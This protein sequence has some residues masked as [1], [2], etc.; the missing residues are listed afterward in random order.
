MGTE[1]RDG[2]ILEVESRFGAGRRSTMSTAISRYSRTSSRNA[3]TADIGRLQGCNPTDLLD[4][5]LNLAFIGCGWR[6]LLDEELL[7]DSPVHSGI[8]LGWREKR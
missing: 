5:V 4:A 1:W 8:R 2:P 3:G 6:A 7:R